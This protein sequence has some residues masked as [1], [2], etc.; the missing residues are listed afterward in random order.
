MRQ[1]RVLP[2]VVVVLSSGVLT[3]PAHAV[4][5]VAVSAYRLVSTVPPTVTGAA[6]VPQT[7]AS[8][9]QKLSHAEA[10]HTPVAA[11]RDA[12]AGPACAQCVSADMF[13]TSMFWRW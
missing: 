5:Q 9:A 6:S 3:N 11:A 13:R 7:F 1:A 8:M 4:M 12:P 10:P 2:A